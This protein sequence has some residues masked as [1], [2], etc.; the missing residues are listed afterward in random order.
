MIQIS[1]NGAIYFVLDVYNDV[2]LTSLVYHAVDLS[3][4]GIIL[5]PGKVTNDWH[6]W[7]CGKWLN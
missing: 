3:I 2:S 4:I 7:F 6:V 1:I 5:F